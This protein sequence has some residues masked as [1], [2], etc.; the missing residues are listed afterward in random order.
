MRSRTVSTFSKFPGSFSGG[1]LGG[2]SGGGVPNITSRTYFPRATGEVRFGKVCCQ[3]FRPRIGQQALHLLLQ[4]YR[5]LKLSLTGKS[6]ELLIGTAAPKEVRQ[7]RRQ[8]QIADTVVLTGSDAI[9][10]SFESENE[11]QVDE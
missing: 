5:I 8:L 11:F 9:R 1:T 6:D 4:H 3:R 7:P 10:S 2:G